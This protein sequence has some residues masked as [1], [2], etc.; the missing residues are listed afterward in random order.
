MI[1]DNGTSIP[2]QVM[3]ELTQSNCNFFKD[4]SPMSV[5]T[6]IQRTKFGNS[7][8]V[9]AAVDHLEGPGVLDHDNTSYSDIPTSNERYSKA[10]SYDVSK[11]CSTSEAHPREDKIRNHISARIE[12]SPM[13]NDGAT[14]NLE[15]SDSASLPMTEEV[16]DR[17]SCYSFL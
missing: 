1:V 16:S 17:F 2:F 10:A 3:R 9:L 12:D 4:R 5:K 15:R 14:S 11:R 13:E 6:D 7:G 8:E